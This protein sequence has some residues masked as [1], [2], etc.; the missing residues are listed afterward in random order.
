M[1]ANEGRIANLGQVKPE[2]LLETGTVGQFCF[3]V[4]DGIREDGPL[5][6]VS[7]VNAKG[8]PAWFDGEKSYI[9]PSKAPELR[10]IR[11]LIQQVKDKLPLHLKNGVFKLKAWHH[12]GSSSSSTSVASGFPRQGR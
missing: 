9:I 7:E 10:E 3:Q 12:P 11:R 6:A 5:L 8:N 4:A 1:G 2:L